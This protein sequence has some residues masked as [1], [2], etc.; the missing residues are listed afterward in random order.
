MAVLAV[1]IEA[2][3]KALQDELLHLSSLMQQIRTPNYLP[4]KKE[5]LF[6]R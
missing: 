3:L 5:E 4:D 1:M 2:K 6:P